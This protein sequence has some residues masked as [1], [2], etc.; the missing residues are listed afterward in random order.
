MGCVIRFEMRPRY[1]GDLPPAMAISPTS[2]TRPVFDYF[3]GAG[4]RISEGF[5]QFTPPNGV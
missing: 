3:R 2:A 1:V 5:R 4:L